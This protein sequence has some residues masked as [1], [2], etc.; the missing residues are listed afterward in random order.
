MRDLQADRGEALTT[1]AGDRS[2]SPAGQGERDPRPDQDPTP[3]SP[4]GPAAANRPE[5]DQADREDT[6]ERQDAAEREDTQTGSRREPAAGTGD[7][8]ASRSDPVGG[9]DSP[10]PGLPEPPRRRRTSLLIAVAVFA[11][12]ADIL[13]KLAVVR[14]LQDHPPVK[15]LGGLFYL[16]HT[17]NT[18]AAF[19]LASG[20]T[21]VLTL[22]A[23]GVVIFILRTARRLYSTGWAVSLGLIL[24]GAS[25]NLADRLLRAPAPL[26]GGVVDFIALLDPYHPPWP[27]FNLADSS[28]VIGVCLAVVLELTGRRIDGTRVTKSATS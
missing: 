20:F 13:S 23:I 16:V 3:T 24:G 21:V 27:V 14:S 28:L 11:L 12:A 26:R 17:R 5:P 6:A 15:I 22:V 8:V 7:P 1:S 25:G 2:D 18:G 19:S 4:P 10:P 9:E